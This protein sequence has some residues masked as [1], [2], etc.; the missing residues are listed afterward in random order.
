MMAMI[1]FAL[2]LSWLFSL[3]CAGMLWRLRAR[4]AEID[5]RCAAAQEGEAHV[6][7]AL[8]LFAHEL[9]SLALC[10]RGHVDRLTQERHQTAP[11]LAVVTSQLA[12]LADELALHLT[13]VSVTHQLRIAEFALAPL[14][15]EAVGAMQAAI[16]PGQRHFRIAEGSRGDLILRVDHRAMRLILARVLAEAIRSSTQEDWIE[17]SWEVSPTGLSLH[18]ADE[19]AGTALPAL[20][21]VAQDSRGIGLRLALARS[22]VQAHGGTLEVEARVGVGTRVMIHLPGALMMQSP[23][24]SLGEAPCAAHILG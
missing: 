20:A 2:T 14:V 10:L 15:A 8:R 18:V 23:A 22:L 24:S 4:F 11:S 9:Q 17:I 5:A 1:V 21:E 16:A 13:P 12:Q 19:G 6:T 3:L 7:R